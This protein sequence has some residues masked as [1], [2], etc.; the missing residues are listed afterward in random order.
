MLAL[1]T[2]LF[3]KKF[4]QRIMGTRTN[5][6]LL[7]SV[8]NNPF[9][10]NFSKQALKDDSVMLSQ[11]E[12]VMQK[13]AGHALANKNIKESTQFM[14]NLRVLDEIKNPPK[15]QVYEFATKKEMPKKVKEGI[16]QVR[17]GDPETLQGNLSSIMSLVDEMQG[18]TPTMRVTKNRQE[19]AD[20]I[21]KMRGKKF[22]NEEIKM[23]KDYADEYS[24][25]LAKEK[26]APA[27]S[28][29]QQMGGKSKSQ[30]ILL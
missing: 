29:T 13:Y 11:A 15:A 12:E 1:L 16:E 2:K 20:F 18:I 22:S 4:I 23:V 24:M 6:Q 3:G 25:N 14:K 26:L 19:L 7:G 5:V 28:K 10:Q 17:G 8:R 21:R 27:I 9:K 30:N